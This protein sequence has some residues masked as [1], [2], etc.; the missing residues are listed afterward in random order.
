MFRTLRTRLIVAFLLATILPIGA[1]VWITTALLERSLGYATTDELDRLSSTLESTVR[2]LYRREREALRADVGAGTV[3]GTVFLARDRGEWP[4]A[5]RAFWDSGEAERFAVSGDGGDH[6]DFFRRDA[7]GVRLYRRHLGGV[8]LDDLSAAFRDARSLVASVEQRDLRRG[9]TL[10]ALLLLAVAWCLSMVPLVLIARR[11]TRPI[12]ELTTALAT[13][14]PEAPPTP[15]RT[16]RDDE[17]GRAV[18]AFNVL[19]RQLHDS[20]E[21]L[22]HLTRM[23]S[24][25]SLARKTAHELKNSLTPIRLTVEEM[26]ARQASQPDTA[27]IANAAQIVVSEIETLERRVRA[28]SEFAAE[29]SVTLVPVSVAAVVEERLTLLGPRFPDLH[30]ELRTAEDLPHAVADADLLKGALTN[31]V[32]NAAEAAGRHGRLLL[33]VRRDGQRVVAEVHD[34]GPGLP[35]EVEATLFQPTITF[36]RHGMGLGL[37]IAKRNALLC[38]GDLALIPGLLGGAGFC[39]TLPAAS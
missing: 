20:R 27:F 4:A 32:Q 17:V 38:G 6:V 14:S 36:K 2:E 39:I 12:T 15:L 31:L 21:R 11:V 25:Q 29:P 3:A 1:A 22:V 18:A 16:W 26:V 7:D 8:R 24:W 5:A 23:A 19:G 13:F 10:T 28:F 30:R 33:I 9:F 37:S 34:S 35:P